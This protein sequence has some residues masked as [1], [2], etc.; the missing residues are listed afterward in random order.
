MPHAVH[1]DVDEKYGDWREQLFQNGYAIVRG[2]VSPKNAA[3]Y[4]EEMTKWLERFPL[5]FDRN[6][7][8][9]WT[10]EHLPAHMKYVSLFNQRDAEL[11]RPEEE[12]I[13][14]TVSPTRNSSGMLG[15]N[16]E[17]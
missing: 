11:T 14:D 16:L 17:S 10:E 9:T 6:D 1:P 12:C 3:G 13:T 8:T 15:W 2:A 7:P 4:V 5:G